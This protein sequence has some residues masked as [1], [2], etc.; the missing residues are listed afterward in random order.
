MIIV[1]LPYREAGSMMPSTI[2]AA[3]DVANPYA[4]VG[5]WCACAFI[6]AYFLSPQRDYGLVPRSYR[7][8]RVCSSGAH[9]PDAR[10]APVAGGGTNARGRNHFYAGPRL[11][12]DCRDGGVDG[13]CGNVG[14]WQQ[15]IFLEFYRCRPA[16]PVVQRSRDRC[17]RPGKRR[18][19][20]CALACA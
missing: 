18:R 16:V 5:L 6:S 17:A 12:H 2:V 20:G 11:R 9:R 7:H 13:G 14:R 3:R 8:Q 10:P 1:Y 4:V 19:H 15:T